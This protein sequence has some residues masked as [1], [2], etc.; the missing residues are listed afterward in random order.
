MHRI[1]GFCLV[2]LYSVFLG[3]QITEACLLVPYWKSLSPLEFYE[4]YSQFGRLIGRFYTILTVI[5]TMTTVYIS[6]H[7]FA[8]SS[9]ARNFTLISC[10]FVIA[11]I[12]LF[13]IYFKGANQKFYIASF[14]SHQLKTE[15]ENWQCCHWL[16]VT[17]EFLTLTFLIL[18][19]NADAGVKNK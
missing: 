7:C 2:A 6:I 12:A 17:F 15:L 16:R 5:S 4:Y 10:F 9:R 1:L 18:A 13:Y 8:K 11:Y 14:N 19:L 3:S